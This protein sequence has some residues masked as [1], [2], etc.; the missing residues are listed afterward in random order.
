MNEEKKVII[1]TSVT[2]A[3]FLQN[4]SI[5]PFNDAVKAHLELL[6][7]E[8]ETSGETNIVDELKKTLIEYEEKKKILQRNMNKS[9][10]KNKII[11]LEEMANL[12]TELLNLEIYGESFKNICDDLEKVNENYKH[13]VDRVDFGK[14]QNSILRQKLNK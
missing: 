2:F 1:T 13:R 14:C 8:K 4:N 7:S 9:N 11:T 6:I 12:K 3:C 10:E 5:T